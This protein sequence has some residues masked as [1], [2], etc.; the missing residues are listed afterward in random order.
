MDIQLLILG[1]VLL[2]ALSMVVCVVV[3]INV[4]DDAAFLAFWIYSVLL[5]F[6][7]EAIYWALHWYF[8]P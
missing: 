7:L 5:F 6:V 3:V 8:V 4:V 2:L 1:H